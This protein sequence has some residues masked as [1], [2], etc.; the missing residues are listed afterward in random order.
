MSD[1]DI[2]RLYSEECQED[3]V[4]GES[5]NTIDSCAWG[6]YHPGGAS[7]KHTRPVQEKVLV[8]RDISVVSTA[9]KLLEDSSEDE[10][11]GAHARRWN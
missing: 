8:S 5:R 4:A 11:T 7:C 2:G 3:W 9:Q 10:T 1:I 6:M